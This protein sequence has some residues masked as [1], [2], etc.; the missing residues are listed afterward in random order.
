M[1]TYMK[2]IA[3]LVC[4]TVP[5]FA[6]LSIPSDGSDGVLNITTST[7]IDLSLAVPG[8]WS[9]NNAANAG[10]GIYDS[11]KWAV[12]FKYQS[13]TI[14]AVATNTFKNHPTHA[15]VVWLVQSNALINGRIDLTGR[16]QTFA[17]TN[18][19]PGPG[20]FRGGVQNGSPFGIGGRRDANATYSSSYGNTR[21]LP[22]IGGSGEADSSG[23][24]AAGGG[25]ILI[26]V[27]STTTVN[28]VIQSKGASGSFLASGG[29]IRIIAD[30]LQGS[31]TLDVV[32]EGRMSIEVN[33]M[34]GITTLPTTPRIP[35]DS[36]PL[37]WPAP[38]SPECRIVSVGSVNVSSDPKADVA[39]SP[40]AIIGG[41]VDVILQTLNFPTS[42]V[43][44]IRVA[45]KL[46]TSTVL[47]TASMVSGSVISATWKATMTLTNGY[48]VM[49]ARAY[50]P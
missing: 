50:V 11:N 34:S 15:P 48:S 12:V 18:T 39:T 26:A 41:P 17:T 30:T 27:A 7:V 43:V 22:L 14:A 16:S 4:S 8:V 40:D 47:Y 46:S 33:N 6:Q 45:P 23:N 28:G 21:V 29:A 38:G 35:P 37:I 49:Q 10:K 19:E 24:S 36:P 13:V 1:K 25:A 32:P 3:V 2:M 44:Q 42:G 9:N 31:G 20:G 5:A